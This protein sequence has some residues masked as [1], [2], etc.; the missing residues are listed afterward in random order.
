MHPIRDS[1]ADADGLALYV[2]EAGR[3]SPLIVLHGGPDFD[4][5][6]L[7]PGMDALADCCR[8]AYFDQRGRGRSKRGFRIEDVGIERAVADVDAVRRHLGAE[9]VAILGHSWGGHLAMQY[10]LRH[11]GHVSRMILLNTAPATNEDWETMIRERGAKRPAAEAAQLEE[12]EASAALL[13]GDPQ[14][15]ARYYR[16]GFS[17][18]FPDPAD[19]DRLD[20]GLTSRDD[21]LVGRDVEARLLETLYPAP[22]FTIV[23]Q[24]ERLRMPTLVIHG[25][26]D[27]IPAEAAARIARAIPGARLEILERS[28][29]FS[30]IDAAEPMGALVRSFI[31]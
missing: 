24:L 9:R 21:I 30:Y 11:P 20:L 12:M 5:T 17:D 27:F 22:G 6:Y 26:Q 7:L 16:I 1:F 13:E 19:L 15:V 31:A 3:G 28:G 23:P 29:H 25:R 10:A 2:R 8:L 18:A 14:A 4:H